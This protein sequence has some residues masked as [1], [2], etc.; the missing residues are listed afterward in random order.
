MSSLVQNSILR[1]NNMF[2]SD[3]EYSSLVTEVTDSLQTVRKKKKESKPED[4][5]D[6]SVGG[7]LPIDDVLPPSAGH[8][9]G[10]NPK[11]PTSGFRMESIEN[12]LFRLLEE[13]SIPSQNGEDQTTQ[14]QQSVRQGQVG[15]TGVLGHSKG[16]KKPTTASD[17]KRQEIDPY[18]VRG[19][20]VRDAKAEADK[21][22]TDDEVDRDEVDDV[23][24]LLGGESETSSSIL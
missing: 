5:D 18:A 6:V 7:G 3:K 17:A 9:S 21:T 13:V 2:M 14:I 10:T 15:T 1:C 11:T 16:D 4:R 19:K 23:D 20:A 24:Q 8:E 12:R 22:R